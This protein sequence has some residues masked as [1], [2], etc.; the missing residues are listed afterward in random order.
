MIRFKWANLELLCW[1]SR[2]PDKL[3]SYQ[4][5]QVTEN[6]GYESDE[7][8]NN[9]NMKANNKLI[10]ILWQKVSICSERYYENHIIFQFRAQS[11]YKQ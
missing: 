8:N 7:M 10:N 6:D 2:V 1:R 3:P 11:T 9:H 5:W 4:I